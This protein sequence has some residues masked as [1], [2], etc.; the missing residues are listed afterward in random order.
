M[1][2]K[3]FENHSDECK[4]EQVKEVVNIEKTEKRKRSESDFLKTRNKAKNIFRNQISKSVE[5]KRASIVKA[6]VKVGKSDYS[7]DRFIAELEKSA[8]ILK[9]SARFNKA[10]ENAGLN[11]HNVATHIAF[12]GESKVW[13]VLK[14]GLIKTYYTQLKEFKDPLYS[15]QELKCATEADCEG[16]PPSG[17]LLLKNEAFQ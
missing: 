15:E 5:T 9:D 7:V 13:L 8:Q 17:G 2:T 12:E 14:D 16:C 6:V 11:T 10:C 4:V 1:E 3:N